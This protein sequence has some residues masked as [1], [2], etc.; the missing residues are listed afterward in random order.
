MADERVFTPEEELAFENGRLASMDFMLNHI[1]EYYVCPE[2]AKIMEDYIKGK[3]WAWT[4]EHLEKAFVVLK[5]LGIF[6]KGPDPKAPQSTP[7]TEE[8]PES[9]PWGDR[10]TLESLQKIPGQ[11]LQRFLTDP[12]YSDEFKAQVEEARLQ[13][14]AKKGAYPWGNKLTTDDL[15][16]MPGEMMKAYM[17]DPKWSNEFKNQIAKAQAEKPYLREAGIAKG[18][19]E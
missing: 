10:L 11:D 14:K 16:A 7:T 12:Q 19:I 5:P 3:R 1:G 17:K 13:P 8:P 9:W 18:E 15:Q 6:K 2:N 4:L